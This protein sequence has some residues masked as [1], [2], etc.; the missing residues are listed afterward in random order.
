MTNALNDLPSSAQIVVL[1]AI[2]K[3]QKKLGRPPST[4]EIG[5]THYRTVLRLRD[6]GLIGGTVLGGNETGTQNAVTRK[7]RKYL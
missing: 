3:L 2:A 4:R 6:K 7:G 1:R 5:M